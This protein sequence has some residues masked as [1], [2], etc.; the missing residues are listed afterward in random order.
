M[1]T[2]AH[3]ILS[4]WESFYVIVGSSAGGLTG[5]WFVVITLV[6][7]SN[8]PR[9]AESTHAFGTPNVVH[10]AAVLV[11]SAILSAPWHSLKDA[12]HL[13]GLMAILGFVY[14]MIVFRRMRRQHGYKPVLEDWL[15]HLA[16]PLIAYASLF[17]GAAGMSH[18]QTWALFL[19]GAVAILQLCI[20]IHNAW[21]TIVYVVAQRSPREPS[22]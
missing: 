11:L 4:Q 13:V 5:L 14:V 20:G 9:T 21:D 7:D 8:I 6:G 3:A 15:F 19:I 22:T 18:E 2:S 12:A 17:F 16:L 10:F 1:E